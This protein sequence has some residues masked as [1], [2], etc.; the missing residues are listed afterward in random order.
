MY[1][2]TTLRKL[3]FALAIVLVTAA[4]C[5][6][7][8]ESTPPPGPSVFKGKIPAP[9]KPAS[10]AMKPIVQAARIQPLLPEKKPLL[11]SPPFYNPKGKLNPFQ[12]VFVTISQQATEAGKKI[13]RKGLRLTPLQK[14]DLSQLKLVGIIVSPAGNKALVED[15]SGKGYV[16]TKGTYVGTNLGRVK[17]ILNDRVIVEE[18]VEDFVSGEMKLQRTELRLQKKVGDV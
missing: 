17:R 14:V 5:G 13:R 3:L 1:N 11:V 2:S 7:Q 9:T 4:A 18:R 6:D 15:P 16:V 8:P 12:S 10:Q